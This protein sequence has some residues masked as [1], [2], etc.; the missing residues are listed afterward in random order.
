MVLARPAALPA[1]KGWKSTTGT[2]DSGIRLPARLASNRVAAGALSAI[3]HITS[4]EHRRNLPPK[5]SEGRGVRLAP[6]SPA[7]D[8]W[9]WLG[10]EGYDLRPAVGARHHLEV[11]PIG[12]GEMR[13]RGEAAGDPDLH[14]Q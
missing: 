14:H 8:L 12:P 4:V 13:G 5:L 7:R 10:R 3:G 6:L 2:L 11:R 1:R 9:R